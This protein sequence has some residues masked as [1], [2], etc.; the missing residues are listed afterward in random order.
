MGKTTIEWTDETWNPLRGCSR[1]SPGCMHCYAEQ[2]ARR[3][4]GTGQPY[5]G[6]IQFTAQ[7]AKWTGVVRPVPE[8]LG[9]PL[10]WKRPRAVFV[11]SMSDLFHPAVSFEYI[12]AVFGAMALAPA[13]VFQILTKR[14]SRMREFCQWLADEGSRVSGP[15]GLCITMFLVHVE[16]LPERFAPTAQ[17]GV[18]SAGR[19]P[20]PNVLLG[21]SVEDQ[22]R[23][24]ARRDALRDV[25][26]LGWKTWV[27]Y[28]PALGAV[29]WSGWSFIDWMVS[30]GESGPKARISRPEWHRATRDWCEGAGVPYCFK[31][32]GAWLPR[33]REGQCTGFVNV[34]KRAA[35]RLLDGCLHDAMPLTA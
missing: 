21:A 29:D 34:G 13:H 12:A 9:A 1:E 30:G 2:V 27:S 31:Q 22:R 6:L 8:K 10:L 23:A 35:G 4:S 17:R 19:W 18:A 33:E 20:L 25:S 24:D 11:Y 5:E 15:Q 7:G 28:E 26:Q 16:A 32:W 14:A 3:F